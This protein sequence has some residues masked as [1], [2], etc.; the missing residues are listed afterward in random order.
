MEALS[1]PPLRFRSR[2]LD[3]GLTVLSLVDSKS[4]TV[5]I[6]VWYKVGSKDDPQGRSGFAHLFEH[7]M[8]KRTKNMRDEMLDRLTEDVGGENNAF[9][10]SDVTVYHETVPSNHLERLLWA[11][12]DR[13]A[14][15]EVDESNFQ[16]E[17]EVVK[18]EYRQSVLADP[19]GLFQDALERHAWAV[20]PYQ[21]PTIGSIADLDSATLQ[22]VLAFHKTFYRPDNATLVV[23]GDFNPAQFDKWVDAYFG[24]IEKPDSEI[25]RVTV[26]EPTRTGERRYSETAP[27][28]PLPAVGMS[29]LTVPIAHPD[30][31]ALGILGGILSGGESSRLHQSLVYSQQ[32]ASDASAGA[33][34]RPDG[35]LFSVTGTCAGGKSVES[36]E[37]A[38][39]AEIEK[40]KNAPPT[41]AELSRAKVRALTGVLAGNETAEGKGMN[42]GNAAVVEGDPERANSSLARLQ[43]VTADEVQRVAAKYLTASNRVVV[44]YGVG[45]NAATANASG[46][47]AVGSPTKADQSNAR[48]PAPAA[49]RPISLPVPVER[50]LRNGLRVLVFSQ[51]GSG[52]VTASMQ[53]RAGSAFDLPKMDGLAAFTADLLTRGTKSRSATALASEMEALGGQISTSASK[54]TAEAQ[55]TVAVPY[56]DGAL[57]L[58]ADVLTAPTFAPAEFARLQKEK[59][60]ELA[61]AMEEPRTL[62][63][64]AGNKRVFGDSPYGRATS[65]LPSTI[66]RLKRDDVARFHKTFYRPD[67]GVLLLCGD[68][69]PEAGFAL[70]EKHFAGWKRGAKPAPKRP[71]YPLGPIQRRVTVIDDPKAGQTAVLLVRPGLARTDPRWA[72]AQ[73]ANS[74]YG[75]GYSSRLNVEVR[76]K[77]GLSYGA[78]SG[79]SGGIGVGSF[80]ASCQ[81]KH[82]SAGE[83]AQLFVN[84]LDKLATAP[85]DD[86]ELAARKSALL[87]P[88]VRGLATTGGLAGAFGELAA[89]GVPL[90]EIGKYVQRAQNASAADIQKLASTALDARYASLILVGDARQFLPDLKKR[91]GQVIVIP[92]A[93]LKLESPTLL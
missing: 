25:P 6:Q 43:A 69:T 50:K 42:L 54:E 18:E 70:A 33:D 86:I 13:M 44:R 1:V 93:R 36:V 2:A 8:F 52:L 62:A 17:R 71:R 80:V 51:P 83:V 19:Y 49:P 10:S 73:V 30:A 46:K 7:L 60:D 29:F 88:F 40:I 91:F 45:P 57:T 78:G 77:R 55:F 3:N 89:L 39:L 14:N 28:V 37:R 16:S 85:V 15:L 75:G 58:L 48:P 68:L 65:G 5:A 38:L 26:R 56:L 59:T 82:P 23:V 90:S 79:L 64:L 9:T 76:I 53:L 12:A 92:K 63:R 74:V 24:P 84:E 61:L 81:T 87:G 41:P 67:N 21:R 66:K 72:L 4:P 31:A 22:D 34:L 27:N 20:H 35:G 47:K 11:E 32:I